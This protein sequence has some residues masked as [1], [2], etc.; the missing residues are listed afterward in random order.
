MTR[1]ENEREVND[2]REATRNKQSLQRVLSRVSIEVGNAR[3]GSGPNPQ[4][5]K[6]LGKKVPIKEK[7]KTK[8]LNRVA[9]NWR[10]AEKRE[11]RSTK[12]VEEGLN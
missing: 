8:K 2:L 1:R 6:T 7:G 12:N 9:L 11:R 4:F 10:E 5:W 3:F